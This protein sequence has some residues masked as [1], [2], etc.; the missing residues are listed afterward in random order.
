MLI[1]TTILIH[2][3]IGFI[4]LGNMG[5]PIATNLLKGGYRLLVYNRTREKAIPLI[6][7]GATLVDQA[8]DV[9]DDADVVFSMLADDS[10]VLSI[11]D[12]DPRFLNRFRPGTIHVSMSTISPETARYLTERH[13]GKGI[14]YV[15]A[16]VIGRPDRAAAGTLFVIL[17][18]PSEA[19]QRIAPLLSKIGQ[20][21][22]DFGEQPPAAN[23]AK[24]IVNF[25]IAAAIE[26]M[27]EAFTLGERNNIRREK[28]A[29]LLSATLFDCI[30]YKGYGEHI[31]KHAYE[32][33]GF[34]LALGWK[35]IRLGLEIA[36]ETQTPMPIA[37]LLRERLLS[38]LAKGRG[39][40]DWSAIALGASD[41][42]GLTPEK[43]K[44][45]T[46]PL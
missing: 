13:S 3:K 23:V 29:E 19:K 30:V 35:D 45:V 31:A 37:S 16:P 33:A 7:L 28:M 2:M 34:R 24:L 11:V 36:Q 14:N 6:E 21:T 8:R 38:A 40:L 15:A 44:N 43:L 41:D 4:G 17:A 12:N 42:A 5:L 32:P 22:F 26:C 1:E 18:G 25:N 39:E 46:S 9:G 10:S 27:A 20:R